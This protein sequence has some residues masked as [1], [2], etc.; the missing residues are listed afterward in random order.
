MKR[1]SEMFFDFQR[2]LNGTKRNTSKII[3]RGVN[4]HDVYNI[5]APFISAGKT[6]IA[7][8]V[9]PRDE[10]ISKVLFFEQ[11]DDIWHPIPGAP[12]FELQDPFV[13]FIQNEIIFGGVKVKENRTGFEWKTV[14]F[15]GPDIYNLTEF[16]HGPTGMKD[17]RLCDLEDGRIAV[18]TRPQGRVGGR[19]MIGYLEIED[20]NDLTSSAIQYAALI[21]GIFHPLDWGGVNEAHLLKNGEIGVLGHGA[22]FHDDMAMCEKRYFAKTFVYNPSR[23]QIR[24]LKIIASR[25][26]FKDGP[27]KRPDIANVVFSSGLVRENGTATLYAGISDAEAHWIEIEDPFLGTP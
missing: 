18:F 14:F 1:V 22:C 21:E 2:E 8:R 25:D 16:S 6:I 12:I 9:E 7:G 27:A 26:Q 17:I 4:G 13:S 5:T 23:H 11:E 10:E 3:F 19:G 24:D 20:L 15:R